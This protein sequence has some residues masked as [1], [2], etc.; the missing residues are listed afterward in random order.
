MDNII[1]ISKA[2]PKLTSIRTVQEAQALMRK[3][4]NDDSVDLAIMNILAGDTVA[5]T[6]NNV[7]ILAKLA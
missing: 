2:N 3:V 6:I 1:F 7:T 4:Y 5:L